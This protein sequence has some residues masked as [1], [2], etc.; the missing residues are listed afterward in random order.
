MEYRA[1]RSLPEVLLELSPLPALATLVPIVC[2]TWLVVS[3]VRGWIRYRH[4]TPVRDIAF[5]ASGPVCAVL[6]S[7]ISVAGTTKATL[8]TSDTERW[9]ISSG[10]DDAVSVCLVGFFC[11][12]VGTVA[13]VLPAKSKEY[14]RE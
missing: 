3:G 13:V 2:T 8:L 5:L 4:P 9:I 10:L 7:I 12:L 11:F 1:D 6:S 14:E